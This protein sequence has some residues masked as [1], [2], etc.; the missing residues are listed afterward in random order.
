MCVYFWIHHP[1]FFFHF[2]APQMP[3]S[4]FPFQT[5]HQTC[6]KC[7]KCLLL[8]YLCLVSNLGTPSDF[9][10]FS[11]F[12]KL[13]RFTFSLNALWERQRG[14]GVLLDISIIVVISSHLLSL[15]HEVGQ[16]CF[17]RF[18]WLE[19]GP[20]VFPKWAFFAFSYTESIHFGAFHFLIILGLIFSWQAP[21]LKI[22]L[23]LGLFSSNSPAISIWIY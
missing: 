21:S 5:L 11:T 19:S 22:N 1:K 14:F 9:E 2:L 13:F 4:C 15:I 18:G 10:S 12:D 16:S 20:Y 3:P 7:Q 23:N 17:K 8:C 6:F